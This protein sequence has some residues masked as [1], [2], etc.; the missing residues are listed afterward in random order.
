M[1]H[2]NLS[3][4]RFIPF[5]TA[6]AQGSAP[7]WLPP[8][9]FSYGFKHIAVSSG[10]FCY[11]TPYLYLPNNKG[12]LF[13]QKQREAPCLPFPM[14]WNE[15]GGCHGDT[16]GWM[17]STEHAAPI[18]DAGA[19]PAPPSPGILHISPPSQPSAAYK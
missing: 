15:A 2:F 18:R 16:V 19:A 17:L 4:P 7:V 12:R 5:N 10:Y 9:T 13:I 1:A 3:S 6:F 11:T 8:W 14:P